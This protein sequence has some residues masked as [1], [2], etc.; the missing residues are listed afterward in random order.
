[1]AD[2]F[3]DSWTEISVGIRWVTVAGRERKRHFVCRCQR[4]DFRSTVSGRSREG[5]PEKMS[6]WGVCAEPA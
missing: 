2:Y 3:G 5:A 1:M 4:D 6:R